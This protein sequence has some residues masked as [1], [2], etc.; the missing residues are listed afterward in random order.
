MKRYLTWGL[1]LMLLA[2]NSF[3]A[4]ASDRTDLSKEEGV[5]TLTV[6][7]NIYGSFFNGTPLDFG[8]TKATLTLSMDGLDDELIDISEATVLLDEGDGYFPDEYIFTGT[9][10]DGPFIDGQTTFTLRPDDLSFVN[11]ADG[12]GWT[13][14]GGDGQG[15]YVYNFTVSGIK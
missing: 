4:F 11:S 6:E 14:L 12:A 3:P 9:K 8:D 2:G 5:P 15:L 10:L 7:S 13:T 1:C